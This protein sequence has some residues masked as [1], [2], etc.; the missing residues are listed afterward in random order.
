MAIQIAT[1]AV[2]KTKD[3]VYEDSEGGLWSI[4]KQYWHITSIDDLI[5]VMEAYVKQKLS[6]KEAAQ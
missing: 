4:P 3:C 1:G 6:D 5:D 2:F